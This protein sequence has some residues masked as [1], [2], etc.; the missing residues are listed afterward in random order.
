MQLHTRSEQDF[1]DCRVCKS[2]IVDSSGRL[3]LLAGWNGYTTLLA[4]AYGHL[5]N[6]KP[7]LVKARFNQAKSSG[8]NVV[9]I[10]GCAYNRRRAVM[11]SASPDTLR[12]S[13]NIHKLV[14]MHCRHGDGGSLVLQTG[15][16]R[17]NARV[18]QHR[19]LCNLHICMRAAARTRST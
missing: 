2:N 9:R 6:G 8:L 12:R 3:V 14:S 15:P 17:Y 5:W 18:R 4:D 19:A 13:S 7:D 10:W 1:V 11:I 16:G